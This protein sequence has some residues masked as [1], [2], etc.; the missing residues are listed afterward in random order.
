MARYLR[1][2]L[3]VEPSAAEQFSVPWQLCSTLTMA[4]SDAFWSAGSEA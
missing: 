2:A 3:R 4:C 1:T